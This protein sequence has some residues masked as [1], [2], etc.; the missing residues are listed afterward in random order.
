MDIKSDVEPSGRKL[1]YPLTT[2]LPSFPDEEALVADFRSL[3]RSRVFTNRGPWTLKFETGVGEILGPGIHVASCSNGTTALELALRALGLHGKVIVPSFTFAATVHAIIN[4]GLEPVFAD[5]CPDTF[6]LTSENVE[7]VMDRHVSAI[8]P[9]H[10]YGR[11]CDVDRFE[12]WRRKGI[13][14]VYDAAHAFGVKYRTQSVGGFGDAETFSFHATKIVH[15]GEGG[16][17][18]TR[19]PDLAKRIELLTNFGFRDENTI[20]L[21]GTNAKMSELHALL[22][23]H[24]LRNFQLSVQKRFQLHEAYRGFLSDIQGLHVLAPQ[25]LVEGTGQYFPIVFDRGELRD[26]TYEALKARQIF[27][28]KYFSPP[29]HLFG[30]YKG[31]WAANCPVAEDVS[32]RVLCLPNHTL[33]TKEDVA[34]V[35]E[36]IRKAVQA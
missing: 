17:V 13:K 3:L 8:L 5:I 14:V 25:D 15:A 11:V 20:D 23:C 34:Y 19:D 16:A 27:A 32:S 1:P 7:A 33:M 29:V 36:H 6:C 26:H 22:G 30:P 4:V 31:R 24:S 35:V 9:V 10:V 18:T 21:V 12:N 2:A 28:R